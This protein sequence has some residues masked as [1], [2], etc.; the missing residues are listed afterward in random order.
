[1][2][3][4]KEAYVYIYGRKSPLNIWGKLII[5][6]PF[7]PLVVSLAVIQCTLE[8]FFIKKE[9]KIELPLED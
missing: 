5:G 1:M 4:L 2:R 3:C 8:F 9:H 7:A 6:V